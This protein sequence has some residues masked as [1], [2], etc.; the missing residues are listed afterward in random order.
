MTSVYWNGDA[1]LW[2]AGVVIN[3]DGDVR[4]DLPALTADALPEVESD[5]D[6]SDSSLLVR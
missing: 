3:E 4:P 6:R 2:R 1:T 5:D